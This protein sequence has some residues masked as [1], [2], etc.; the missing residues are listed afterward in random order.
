[1]GIIKLRN[2]ERVMGDASDLMDLYLCQRQMIDLL[3]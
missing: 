1:M 2:K 3:T